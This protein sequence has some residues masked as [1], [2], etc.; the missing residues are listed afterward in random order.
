MRSSRTRRNMRRMPADQQQTRPAYAS[1]DVYR[2]VDIITSDQLKD[3]AVAE[4]TPPSGYAAVPAQGQ[5]VPDADSEIGLAALPA[6]AINETPQPTQRFTPSFARQP[7]PRALDVSA[8]DE[9]ARQ[10]TPQMI[11]VATVVELPPA[12][13]AVI[14]DTIPVA[15]PVTPV[16]VDEPVE[17]EDEDF[18]E[19]AYVEEVSERDESDIATATLRLEQALATRN[20]KPLLPALCFI[21]GLCVG[22]CAM[23]WQSL[24]HYYGQLFSAP[25][26]SVEDVQAANENV[27][28]VEH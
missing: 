18:F 9:Y 10:E 19:D 4:L 11:P 25:Q 13:S 24:M 12:D 1:D 27:P 3:G 5:S 26:V 15:L 8:R 28:S 6:E 7:T 21:L 20:S 17:E 16:F 2:N 23:Q 22:V 14:E